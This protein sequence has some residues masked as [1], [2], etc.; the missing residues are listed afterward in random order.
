M[1]E[2]ETFA[3]VVVL[4]AESEG[5]GLREETVAFPKEN[6]R[7]DTSARCSRDLANSCRCWA[8]DT[9]WT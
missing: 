4:V 6:G 3:G 1:G 2:S 7:R 8:L 5:R 9:R